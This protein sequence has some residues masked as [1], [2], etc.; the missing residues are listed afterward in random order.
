[1]R[2]GLS[3]HRNA[4]FLTHVLDAQDAHKP[5]L[6]EQARLLT[7]L[8][9]DSANPRYRLDADRLGAASRRRRRAAA[10]SLR[11]APS[12]RQLARPLRAAQ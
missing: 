1:M 10:E 6:R 7:V 3:R 9:I 12:V 4:A 8:G 11:G 2:I 5:V